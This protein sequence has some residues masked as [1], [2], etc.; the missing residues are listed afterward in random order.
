MPSRIL[1]K[2]SF[3]YN[4][5]S[6]IIHES[7]L[8]AVFPKA[9]KHGLVIPLFQSGDIE[10]ISNYRPIMNLYFASNGIEK[11]IALQLKS[12]LDQHAVFVEH[13]SAYRN[14][15]STETAVLDLTSNL[16]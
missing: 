6:E 7:F 5:M 1:K 13:Q 15:Y 14:Y 11:V 12:F 9:F 10:E 16:L 8:N 3:F 4:Q 2:L